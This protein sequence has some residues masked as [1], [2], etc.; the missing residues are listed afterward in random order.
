MRNIDNSLSSN[1]FNLIESNNKLTFINSL[2]GEKYLFKDILLPLNFIIDKE[3]QLVFLYLNSGLSALSAYFSFLKTNHAL[4]LLSD[5]LDSNLKDNLEKKYEPTLIYDEKRA[6]ILNY[7]TKKTKNNNFQAVFFYNHNLKTQLA[8]DI[9][10]LL[11]TSGTTG[12]PKLVKLSQNNILQNAISISDYLPI[13]HNDVVPLNLPLNYSYGLSVLHSNAI[14]GG[15]IVCGLPDILDRKFWSYLD[16][17]K[18]TSIAGVPFIYEMLNRIGFMKKKYPS[19]KYI[20]QAGGNL[21]KNIKTK[22]NDYC[23]ENDISFFVMY[24]QT[25]ATARISYVPTSQLKDKITSIGIPIK[26]GKIIIDKD[27]EELLYS[28]P[29]V[30]GGY[31]SNKLDLSVWENISKLK[32]GDLAY[33]DDEGFYYIKGRLKRIVKVFGNRV[34]LDEIEAFIKTTLNTSLLACT[35]INDEFI[36]ITLSNNEIAEPELKK[37]IFEKYKIHSSAIKFN[38]LENLPKTKNEKIDYKSINSLY[39]NQKE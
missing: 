1:L 25:E 4:V 10:I 18:F 22:F 16:T 5:S 7:E 33:K 34:N 31:A 28:G 36:L 29:N 15:T 17:Y 2:D 9:K 11:S 37:A 23:I 12:S 8:Q 3:K 32:T 6:S 21:S 24:G 39:L 20:S 13:N 19:L 14:C 26:N 35:G 30:F 27:T 38:Y